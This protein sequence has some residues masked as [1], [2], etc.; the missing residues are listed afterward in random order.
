MKEWKAGAGW[1]LLGLPATTWR[2]WTSARPSCAAIC[3]NSWRVVQGAWHTLY[4]GRSLCPPY[5]LLRP[6][7]GFTWVPV[8]APAGTW[9]SQGRFSGV[10][11]AQSFATAVAPGHT[12]DLAPA[13]SHWVAPSGVRWRTSR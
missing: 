6:D 9:G 4:T 5:R 2:T 1:C 3:V 8:P 13:A 12:R 11:S 7:R 10:D